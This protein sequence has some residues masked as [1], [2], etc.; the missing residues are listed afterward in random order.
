[1]RFKNCSNNAGRC[2][3]QKN[4]PIRDLFEG[5]QKEKKRYKRKRRNVNV[6]KRKDDFFKFYKTMQ[7]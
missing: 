6:K 4:L 5:V 3:A 2:R 1:M 7:T